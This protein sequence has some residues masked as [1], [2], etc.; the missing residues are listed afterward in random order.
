M[1]GIATQGDHDKARAFFAAWDLAPVERVYP[2]GTR[3]PLGGA[4]VDAQHA[5][6][7]AFADERAASVVSIPKTVHERDAALA[8][9]R[10]A[11][12]IL[13]DVEVPL[14]RIAE[15][16]ERQAMPPGPCLLPIDGGEHCFLPEHHTGPCGA[17]GQAGPVI[18]LGPY[19]PGDASF[20]VTIARRSRVVG[21]S[22]G[23]RLS[24]PGEESARRVEIGDTL[25]PGVT[26]IALASAHGPPD[27]WVAIVD[28]SADSGS[29]KP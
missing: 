25:L 17:A 26:L 2:D 22:P 10:L 6:A 16:L 4:H 12:G 15:F 3:I 20:R 18:K 5:L 7:Q 13:C 29:V 27:W 1:K 8:S 21:M 19:N 14:K 11:V 28:T 9:L 23:V 24:I